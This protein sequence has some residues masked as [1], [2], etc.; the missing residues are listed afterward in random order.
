MKC[1]IAKRRIADYVDGRLRGSERLRV[2]AHL[3]GC[4]SC[5]LRFEQIHSVR[6]ALGNLPG[7]ASPAALSTALRV[8]AS[9]E[10][11]ATLETHGSRLQR[12]WERWKMRV[13]DF[14]RPLTIPAT[15]G[16]LSSV[17]LFGGFAFT[18]GS[19]A[20][21]V[22]YEV[23]VL[24]AYRMHANLVP[25]QLQSSVTLTLSLDPNGRITD[26]TAQGASSSFVGDATRLHHNNIALPAFRSVLALP[27][28]ISSDISIRFTPMVFRQ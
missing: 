24:N 5:S 6:S 23:P 8:K 11:Q 13:D 12:I 26:Y 18:V 17:I 9:Q 27:Q 25:L 21:V 2:A 10:R 14:M 7:T 4:A 1:W 19:Y 28:P 20:S 16:L 3:R 22:S 15:G